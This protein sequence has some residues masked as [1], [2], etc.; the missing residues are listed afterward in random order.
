MELHQGTQRR[1]L[2]LA[3]LLTP[4]LLTVKPR[5]LLI[6]ILALLL[7]AA[8]GRSSPIDEP[9]PTTTTVFQWENPPPCGTW[10]EYQRSDDGRGPCQGLAPPCGRLYFT[11]NNG[12]SP[13]TTGGAS[14]YYREQIE[15]LQGSN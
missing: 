10:E 12:R 15:P 11:T 7:T 14:P 8:C 1:H 6:T 5:S 3:L 4:P 13:T 9:K 2:R